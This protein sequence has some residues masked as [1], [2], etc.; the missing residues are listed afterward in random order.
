MI[1]KNKLF[2]QIHIYCSLFFLPA[3]LIFALS[4]LLF[5]FDFHSSIGMEEQDY[6]LEKK[7]EKGEEQQ[8][9]LNFLKEQGIKIPSNTQ[10]KTGKKNNTYV[11]GGV[12]YSIIM[13]LIG[14]NQY[15]ITTQT[16]SVL[17]DMMMLHKDKGEW[18][19]SVLS[20]G[21]GIVLFLL[22]ISGLIIT[23]FANKKERK[24]Q[25]IVFILGLLVTVILF[26]CSV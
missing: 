17:G 26:Y 22:Y 2:R 11:M 21:L 20:V 7:I 4:G 9:L 15:K 10:L 3:A 19:F 8:Q 14:E 6:I 24:G 23:F 5:L 1:N 25:I 16:R 12:H 18:Y 13:T